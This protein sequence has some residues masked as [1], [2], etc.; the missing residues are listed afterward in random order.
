MTRLVWDDLLAQIS[1][2]PNRQGTIQY[3]VF[4]T[5]GAR[6]LDTSGSQSFD[7]GEIEFHWEDPGSNVETVSRPSLETLFS[8]STFNKF[9]MNSVVE[10]PILIEHKEDKRILTQ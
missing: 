2:A 9:E 1:V 3:G 10:N 5:V 4:S 7:L 8:L 6:E